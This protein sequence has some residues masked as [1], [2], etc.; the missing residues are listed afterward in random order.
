[1]ELSYIIQ[2]S[3]RRSM[4]IHVADDWKSSVD[5]IKSDKADY[6]SCDFRNAQ[7]FFV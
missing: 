1:M 4:S 6:N 2:K 7:L 5:K 3:R